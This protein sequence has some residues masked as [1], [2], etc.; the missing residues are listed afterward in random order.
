[1]FVRW[2]IYYDEKKKIYL[3]IDNRVGI[4]LFEEFVLIN[5]AY[6]WLLHLKPAQLLQKVEAREFWY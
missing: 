6:I 3:A 2:F 1:M 4:F 5:D